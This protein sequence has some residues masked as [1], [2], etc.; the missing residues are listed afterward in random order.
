MGEVT[1]APYNFR[2]ENITLGCHGFYAKV[3]INDQF[4]VTNIVNV[5]VGEQVPYSGK[6]DFNSG[7][8]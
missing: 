6:S 3:Y 1:S 8:Y 5:Q 2:A 4:N 7:C